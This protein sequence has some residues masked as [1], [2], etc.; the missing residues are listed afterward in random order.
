MTGCRAPIYISS[1]SGDFSFLSL[2]FGRFT[3]LLMHAL[4][5]WIGQL[6]PSRQPDEKKREGH[7][8]AARGAVGCG[9]GGVAGSRGLSSALRQQQQPRNPNL[10]ISGILF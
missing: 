2:Y 7:V 1:A 8:E 10:I 4:A 3:F 5:S 6:N 9:C